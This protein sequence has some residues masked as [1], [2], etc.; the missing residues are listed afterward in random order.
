MTPMDTIEPR[1]RWWGWGEDG[2]DGPV[3]PGAKK[4]LAATCGWPASVNLPPV[5]LADVQ[6]PEAELSADARV[7]FE[8]LLGAEYVRDDHA[9]RVS[10]QA[11]RNCNLV[12][13]LE[14]VDF[15]RIF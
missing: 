5:E 11:G 7:R 9:T 15:T 12:R 2:H 3:K 8:A 14:I 6:L 1:M 10:P 13:H 4:M